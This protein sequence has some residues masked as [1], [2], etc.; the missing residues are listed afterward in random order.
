MAAPT[1]IRINSYDVLDK[2]LNVLESNLVMDQDATIE[3]N[4]EVIYES[5]GGGSGIRPKNPR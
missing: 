1:Y 3:E 5:N 4:G 2:D